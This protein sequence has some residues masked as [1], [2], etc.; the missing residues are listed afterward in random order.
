MEHH[1]TLR[2]AQLERNDK[3]KAGKERSSRDEQLAIDRHYHT[4]QE[5]LLKE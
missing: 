3:Y 2:E 4:L 1:R 5:Q